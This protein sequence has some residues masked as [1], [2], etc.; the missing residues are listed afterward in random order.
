MPLGLRGQRDGKF[1]EG[2]LYCVCY[3][4]TVSVAVCNVCVDACACTCGCKCKCDTCMDTST[5]MC[6]SANS[7]G[8]VAD[9]GDAMAAFLSIIIIA[10]EVWKWD[11]SQYP[12]NSL[13]PY[14]C[15]TT[16]SLSN[17]WEDF[18]L[19]KDPDCSLF[20]ATLDGEM[21]RLQSLGLGSTKRQAEVITEDKEELLWRKGS[22]GVSTPQQLLDIMVFYSGLF[23]ALRSRREHKQLQHS[24]GER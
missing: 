13:Y 17:E 9:G 4:C 3:A 24:P 16:V 14:L 10:L 7:C 19:L 2:K 11:G 1:R 12:P 15:R 6:S 8:C 20:P 21:K 18:D 5:C 23:S 22:L